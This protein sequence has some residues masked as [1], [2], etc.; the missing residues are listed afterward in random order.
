MDGGTM[1]PARFEKDKKTGDRKAT[2]PE[3]AMVELASSAGQFTSSDSRPILIGHDSTCDLRL[4]GGGV[5]RFH[6]VVCWDAET[7]ERGNVAEAGV[8]IEDLHSGRGTKLNGQAVQRTALSDGDTVE[9]AGHRITVSFTGNIQQRAQALA[10]VKPEAGKLAMTCI[11]GPDAG[12]TFALNPNTADLVLGRE[13]DTDIVFTDEEISGH[14]ARITNEMADVGG[15][16]YRPSFSIK[17]LQST[18]GTAV[19][20]HELKKGEK[21]KLGPGDIVRLGRG[22]GHC[23]V[24]V[25]YARQ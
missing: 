24:L 3:S 22:K 21:Y 13:P 9:V 6:A 19:N 7:D 5:A 15:G 23:D 20:R 11:E 8:F 17:D 10:T 4:G 14:H 2:D 16:T 25:H 12:L 18:N 1:R